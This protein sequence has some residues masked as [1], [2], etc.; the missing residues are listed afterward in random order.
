M[1]NLPHLVSS[2]INQGRLRHYKHAKVV[3]LLF[4]SSA[5]HLQH[6]TIDGFTAIIVI[7]DHMS[8]ADVWI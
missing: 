3:Y 1:L 5:S 7:S 6:H 2:V 4:M 8:K